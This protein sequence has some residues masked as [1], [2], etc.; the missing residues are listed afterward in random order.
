VLQ[1]ASAHDEA[2]LRGDL[3]AVNALD[4]HVGKEVRRPRA[5]LFGPVIA[6]RDLLHAL[7]QRLLPFVEPVR[8]VGPGILALGLVER[9]VARH[10]HPVAQI[11]VQQL[12]P[13]I[14]APLVEQLVLEREE[15]VDLGLEEQIVE[16]GHAAPIKRAQCA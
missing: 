4:A 1:P 13:V 3:V 8:F 5:R 14:E 9:H 16:R 15:A 12:E 10:R 6:A 7:A 2:A 11:V